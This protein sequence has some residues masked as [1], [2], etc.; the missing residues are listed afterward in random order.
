MP[1]DL[2]LAKALEDLTLEPIDADGQVF[3]ESL[4]E[5]YGISELGASEVCS[6]CLP[7]CSCCCCCP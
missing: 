5:G 6:V 4:M 2:I 3:E 7:S 1:I